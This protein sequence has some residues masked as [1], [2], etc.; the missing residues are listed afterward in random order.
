MNLSL[1]DDTFVVIGSQYFPLSADINT[2]FDKWVTRFPETDNVV[3]G[4][5]LNVNLKALG[6]ARED[7]R[8]ES[9]LEHLVANNLFLLNDPQ[10]E[11]T[12][13]K[14]KRKGKPDVTLGGTDICNDLI[15]WIVDSDTFSYSD[16]KYIRFKFKYKAVRKAITRYKTKNKSF[17]RFNRIFRNEGSSLE[18]ELNGVTDSGAVET[19]MELFYAVLEKVMSKCFRRGVLSHKPSLKWYTEVFRIGRNQV[20]AAYKRMKKYPDA[21]EY[22]DTYLLTRNKYKRNHRITRK[23]SLLSFCEK[24]SDAFGTVYKYIAGKSL[25]HTDLVFTTWENS[26]V[27]DT[28]DDVVSKLMEEYFRISQILDQIHYCIPDKDKVGQTDLNWFTQRA[29]ACSLPAECYEGTGI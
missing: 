10:A 15:Y 8:T 4:A 9:F 12:W 23:K 2:D 5:D 25:H 24:S 16:H 17:F 27:F 11:Y 18:S 22:R 21:Q 13:T 6:Y 14:E 1:E 19:W 3:L 26:H 28:Y 20:N 7:D 29:E